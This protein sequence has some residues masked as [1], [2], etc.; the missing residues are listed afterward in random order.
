MSEP[1]IRLLGQCIATWNA[2][3][4]SSYQDSLKEQMANIIFL[5]EIHIFGQKHFHTL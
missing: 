5:P 3:S 2:I 4:Q 1:I